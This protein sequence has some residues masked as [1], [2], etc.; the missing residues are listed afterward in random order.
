MEKALFRKLYKEKREAMDADT[1]DTLSLSIAN[2]LLK[3]PLW[4][5]TYYHLFLNIQDKKEVDTSYLLHILQGRDKSIA[6][7][8]VNSKTGQLQ[9]ILLQE[10]TSI[11]IASYGIPEPVDGVE[12]APG[13]MD[14]VFVP[15]LAYDKSGNR[16][17]YGKGF[18]DKFLAQCS[19]ECKFVGLSFFEPEEV[20]PT[21]NFDIPLHFCVSP[22]QWY[23]F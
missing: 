20:I 13:L 15:L 12:L 19:S 6:V 9:S 18:Y 16:L 1:I 21:S 17:G 10:N 2:T 14:V 3:L 4:D 7:P 11:K 5:K 23:E 8:K 22:N